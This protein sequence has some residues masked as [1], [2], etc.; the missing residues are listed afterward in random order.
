VPRKPY[1]GPGASFLGR[2]FERPAVHTGLF[3]TIEYRAA[4][5]PMESHLM[6]FREHFL[7]NSAPVP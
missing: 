7:G 1:E 4:Q 6:H 2:P 3:G 5:R